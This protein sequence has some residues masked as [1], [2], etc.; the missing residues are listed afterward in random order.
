M[1][2]S[3]SE[4][5]VARVEPN[6]PVVHMAYDTKGAFHILEGLQSLSEG[7]SKSVVVHLCGEVFPEPPVS[8]WLQ[9]GPLTMLTAEQWSDGRRPLDPSVLVA[10]D[11]VRGTI[12][13]RVN[14]T[15]AVALKRAIW[16][17]LEPMGWLHD[18]LMTPSW[19]G[20]EL[21]EANSLDPLE[22]IHQ[23]NLYFL[24]GESS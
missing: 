12:E 7:R 19:S 17:T 24:P 21:S 14:C 20:S 9:A 15:G 13:M 1:R 18:H 23:L 3:G 5:V 16:S 4:C 10:V 6:T 2:C 22:T 8:T 11:R